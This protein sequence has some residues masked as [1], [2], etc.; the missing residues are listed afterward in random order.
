MCKHFLLLSVDLTLLIQKFFIRGVATTNKYVHGKI[1]K[2][3]I[4]CFYEFLPEGFV[5]FYGLLVYFYCPDM[6][7]TKSKYYV[8]L[9]FYRTDNTVQMCL[10]ALLG[11]LL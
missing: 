6:D 3:I 2:T 9:A 4:E 8:R 7:A 5:A 11:L 10:D 1:P